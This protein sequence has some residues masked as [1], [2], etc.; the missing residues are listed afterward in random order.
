MRYVSFPWPPLP[1]GLSIF[2]FGFFLLKYNF[3]GKLIKTKEFALNI[4]SQAL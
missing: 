1:A 3:K 2:N 4:E